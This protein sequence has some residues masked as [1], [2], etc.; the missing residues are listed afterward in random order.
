MK[1]VGDIFE[2]M[3]MPRDL[4]EVLMGLDGGDEKPTFRPGAGVVRHLPRMTRDGLA[5]PP[6]RP[7]ARA[8]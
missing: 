8:S 6:L 3:S 1:A 2:A 7:R 4:L 5:A